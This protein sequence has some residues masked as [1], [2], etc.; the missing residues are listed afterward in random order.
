[1]EPLFDRYYF[2]DEIGLVKPEREIF[3]YVISDLNVTPGRIAFFDDT[4][5]NVEGARQAGMNAYQTDGV[6]ELGARLRTL[7]V[8]SPERAP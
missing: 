3:E 1:M 4:P 6:D 7:G 8:L 2:S 5:I